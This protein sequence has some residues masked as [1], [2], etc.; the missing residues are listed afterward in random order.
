M[1]IVRRSKSNR[2]GRH[3]DNLEGVTLTMIQMEKRS[4][5]DRLCINLVL[6]RPKLQQVATMMNQKMTYF[7]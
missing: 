6:L 4:A 2:P 7:E 3:R 5:I 1:K